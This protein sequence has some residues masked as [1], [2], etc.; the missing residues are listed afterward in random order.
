VNPW[1]NL[2]NPSTCGGS[3]GFFWLAK[4]WTGLGWLTKSS[5]CSGSSWIESGRIIR[6]DSSRIKL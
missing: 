1:A 3:F 2:F 4:K 5:T 6:F